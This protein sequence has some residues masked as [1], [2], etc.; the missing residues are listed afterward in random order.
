MEKKNVLNLYLKYITT[1]LNCVRAA[2]HNFFFDTCTL[3]SFK[4]TLVVH[5]CKPAVE[6]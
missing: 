1:Y 6:E 2:Y 3:K 5:N 4:S